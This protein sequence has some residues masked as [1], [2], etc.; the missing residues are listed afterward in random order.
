VLRGTNGRVLFRASAPSAT[1]FIRASDLIPKFA[2]GTAAGIP[3]RPLN[4]VFTI[5]R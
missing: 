3:V 2:I 1:E 5:D 4:A